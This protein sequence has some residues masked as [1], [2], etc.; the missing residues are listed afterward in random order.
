ME[1][2]PPSSPAALW[3]LATARPNRTA[4][5]GCEG[6]DAASR[7]AALWAFGLGRRNAIAHNPTGAGGS[8]VEVRAQEVEDALLGDLAEGGGRGLDA[9]RTFGIHGEVDVVAGCRQA[10]GHEHAFVQQPVGGADGE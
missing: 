8:A 9:M 10:G 3:A 2:V 7:R 5:N 6:V 1:R 4:H